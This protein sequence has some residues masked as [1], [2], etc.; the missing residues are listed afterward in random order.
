MNAYFNHALNELGT[1]YQTLGRFPRLLLMAFATSLLVAT[2]VFAMRPA[3]LT[4][5]GA[6]NNIARV[7]FFS[8]WDQ[9]DLVVLVRHME[10]CDRSTN[11]CLAQPDGITAKGKRVA[12]QLGLEFQKLGLAQANIY[13]SPLRRT[14]QTATFAFNR[15]TADQ[16]W[17][18][19]CRRSMLD[20]VKA[21]KL[22]HHNLILVTHSECIAALQK[23]LNVPSPASLDYG[24]SLVISINP[25]DGNPHVMGYVDAQDWGS[26][27][28]KRP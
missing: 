20:D 17:L 27:L 8:L 23:S 6:G 11:P 13:N 5:L 14:E 16:D 25:S 2:A 28:A 15:T 7:Q 18:I 24:A 10:R 22:D 12:D 19:D 1:R 9:G 26:I 21:H 4:D 3:A